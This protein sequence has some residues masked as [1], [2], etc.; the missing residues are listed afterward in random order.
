VKFKYKI[1]RLALK[2]IDSIWTFTSQNW[3]KT[4]ANIYFKGVLKQIDLICKNPKI[5]KS[6]DE[7]KIGHRLVLFKS[8]LIIY[9]IEKEVVL[10]DRILHQRM[11]IDSNL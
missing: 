8:H 2:D 7:V 6:I 11:D 1:S 5:G 4:Q 10:V 3:S 9:K